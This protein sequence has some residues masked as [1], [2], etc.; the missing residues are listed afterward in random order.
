[1]NYKVLSGFIVVFSIILSGCQESDSHKDHTTTETEEVKAPHVDIL[2]KEHV[3]KGEEVQI[4]AHVYYGEELVDDA[5]VQFEI[6]K[7][8]HSEKIDAKLVDKGTY[9]INYLF[10]ED[11]TYQVTAHTNVKEYHTMPTIDIQVGEGQTAATAEEN[12]EEQPSHNSDHHDSKQEGEHSHHSVNITVEELTT[13]QLNKEER[14]TTTIKEGDQPF[15]DATV[16]FEIWMEGE[17]QHHYIDAAESSTKG[18]YTSS[19][20]FDKAGM[21][22]IVVHV[23]KGEIHDHIETSVEVQ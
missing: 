3:K 12:D 22:T 14:L 6:Q 11:G 15:L 16:R 9:E 19:Y 20:K 2:A 13:F 21:Y 7:G 23:E 17:E 10:K 1:M 18:T 5:E 4:G 8:D